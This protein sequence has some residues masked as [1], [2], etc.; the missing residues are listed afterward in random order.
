MEG[1]TIGDLI[2]DAIAQYVLRPAQ[3]E[4]TGTMADIRTWDFGPGTERLSEQ[5]DEILYDNPHGDEE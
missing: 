5:I 2:N 3:F 1:R 4:K